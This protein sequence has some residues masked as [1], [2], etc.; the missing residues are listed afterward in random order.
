MNELFTDLNLVQFSTILLFQ[1]R[2][3][4]TDQRPPR[5]TIEAGHWL[6]HST[7]RTAA[8]DA[9]S[10]GLIQGLGAII[11]CPDGHGSDPSPVSAR[12]PAKCGRRVAELVASLLPQQLKRRRLI[13]RYETPARCIHLFV[14][15][16]LVVEDY[17]LRAAASVSRYLK[18][19]D[20]ETQAHRHTES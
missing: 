2:E 19:A 20:D 4:V 17:R 9:S 14:L 13:E 7:I 8:A 1:V 12:C 18:A 3:E 15:C 11:L 5:G 16:R 10:A 6:H